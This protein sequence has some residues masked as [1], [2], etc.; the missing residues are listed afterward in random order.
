MDMLGVPRRHFADIKRWSDDLAV[1]IGSA[2]GVAGKYERARDGMERMAEFFRAEISQRRSESRDDVISRL[3]AARDADDRLSEDELIATCIL[4]LFA[5]HE[6]TTNAIAGALV[7][8]LRHPEEQLRV[9]SGMVPIATAIE[10]ALRFDG[11]TNAVCRLVGRDHH[12]HGKDLRVGDR[13]FAMVNAANRDPDVFE[14]PQAFDA[15]RTPNPHLTFGQGMH[16]CIGA[17]LARL[18]TQITVAALLRRF[19]RVALNEGPI[20]WRDS[21]IMRGP[22]QVHARLRG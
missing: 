11:P 15:A 4:V 17:P 9:A 10:E 12:M 13:V 3:V 18:E 2:R 14:N 6:T 22:Q 5:G 16:F 21:L 1:F 20:V 19:P 8:L 7:H